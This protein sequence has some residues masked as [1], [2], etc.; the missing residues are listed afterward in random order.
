MLLPALWWLLRSMPP[1]PKSIEFPGF[2]LLKNI[3]PKSNTAATTPW[4]ILLLRSLLLLSFIIAFAEPVLNPVQNFEMPQNGSVLLVVDNN[5]ASASNWQKRKIKIQDYINLAKR[6]DIKVVIIPTAKSEV[7]NKIHLYNAMPAEDAAQV[8]EGLKPQPW[9]ADYKEVITQMTE[10]SREMSIGKVVFF[11]S[12]IK[13]YSDFIDKVDA[14]VTDSKINNPYIL[15]LKN[16]APK[17]IEFS[18]ERLVVKDVDD[19]LTLAAYDESGKVIDEFNFAYPAGKTE[20]DFTWDILPEFQDKLARIE[21]KGASMA[22]ATVVVKAS[23]QNRIVG[24]ISNEKVEEDAKDLLSGYYYIEKALLP[25]AQVKVDKL[26]DLLNQQVSALVLPD[27]T[28]LTADDKVKL[29]NWVEQGGF[30]IR[31]A[32]SNLAAAMQ[33]EILPVTLRYGERS[34]SGSM[35]WERPLKLAKIA[36]GSPLYGLDVPD[37]IE[38]RSQVLAEPSSDVFNKTWLQLEDGT[39]LITGGTKGK[40]NVVL[41]HTTASPKWS[42]FCYSGLFVEALQRMVMMGNGI[43]DYNGQ[44]ELNPIAVLDGFGNLHSAAGNHILKSIVDK[45]S[46]YPSALTPP[47]IY[48]DKYNFKVFNLGEALSQ[49][50]P[51]D[52]PFKKNVKGYEEGNGEKNLKPLFIE[53]GLFL[54]IFETLVTLWLKGA[55]FV[56]VFV[57]LSA[58]NA[59][60]QEKFDPT[61]N[62]YFAYIETGDKTINQ[63]SYNGLKGLADV[64]NM[65]TAVTIAGVSA[66]DPDNSELIYYPFIYWPITSSQEV[67]SIRASQNIQN[68]LLNGGII[69]FDTR[70]QQFKNSGVEATIGTE[71]LREITSSIEIPELVKIPSDHI[72]GRS[73]YLLDS[74]PGQ[75]SGGNLWVEKE[76]NPA[77]D[78]VTSVI[79]GSNNWAAA[80]SDNPSDMARYTVEPDGEMQRELAYKF[81]VNLLM[82]ALTGNYKADQIHVSHILERIGK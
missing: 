81:G 67:L 26:E 73:F 6:N 36:E 14:V 66:V 29:K 21:V 54:L 53:I 75:Y 35:T 13:A 7:D 28:S 22:S 40:G 27:S 9:A 55:F 52:I 16:K 37:D 41:I 20:H 48:G 42:N 72:L 10:A 49:M 24:V 39:P 38:V 63:L 3:K 34:T 44:N 76:P 77:N 12:G 68:Y 56:F 80:W 59:Y 17:S 71:K 69:L 18:L 23:N 31:F 11:S 15:K 2:F 79:I 64:I 46:F 70:D 33:D 32:G 60:A 8:I 61:N 30:L 65:R 57:V 43:S 25:T 78:R 50:K 19:E 1:K 45:N 58:G 47:G 5:W 74:Y 4:W 51:L 82:V 62:I